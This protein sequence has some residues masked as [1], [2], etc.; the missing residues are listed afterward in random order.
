MVMILDITIVKLSELDLNLFLVLLAVLEEG[1]VT[2]A[3]RRLNVTAPAVSNALGR[4]RLALGDPLVVRSGRGITTTDRARK[5]LPQLRE[6]LGTLADVADRGETF[7]PTESTRTFSLVCADSEQSSVLPA[8][9]RRFASELPRAVLAIKSV[10]E[11]HAAGGIEKLE[12]DGIMAP[13]LPASELSA[14]IFREHLFDDDAVLVVRRGHPAAARAL[15]APRFNALRHVDIRLALGGRGIG[16]RRAQ[17]FLKRE[18]LRRDVAVTVPSFSAAILLAASTDL[19]A[20]VP[21][22][23]A[24]VYARHLPIR[25]L[26]LP[27]ASLRFSMDLLWHERVHRDEA[28]HF[29]RRLVVYAVHE[30]GD[31]EARGRSADR[32][33][34]VAEGRAR[35]HR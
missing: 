6:A 26:A 4:L 7:R 1:S 20:A 11:L 15:T 30:S 8:V 32:S 21:R 24:D 2:R 27:G 22:R 16:N 31:G 9:A 17:A 12:V 33:R 29:F 5:M 35:R 14:G 34:S 10:D 13:T 18:G 3:A 28:S 19:A 23:F 25:V